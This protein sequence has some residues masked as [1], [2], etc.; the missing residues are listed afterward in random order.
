MDQTLDIIQ[1]M[2]TGNL[3]VEP[4]EGMLIASAAKKKGNLGI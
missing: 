2:T 4:V 3:D 1:R